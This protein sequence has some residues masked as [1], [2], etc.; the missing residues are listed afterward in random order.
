MNKI[1]LLAA[2]I[3]VSIGLFAYIRLRENETRIA[4][5]LGGILNTHPWTIGAIFSLLFIASSL[6]LFL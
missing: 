6:Y 2:L 5:R 4:A 3:I 1:L